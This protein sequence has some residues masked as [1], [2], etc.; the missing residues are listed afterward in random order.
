MATSC[1][2]GRRSG[3]DLALL[4][5][6][7]GPLAVA[8][9][10]PLARELPYA[11]GAALERKKYIRLSHFLVQSYCK[12]VQRKEA[13]RGVPTTHCASPLPD[14]VINR[15]RARDGH[16]L[17]CRWKCMGSRGEVRPEVKDQHNCK[18]RLH[19]CCCLVIMQEHS[20]R[21]GNMLEFPLWRGGNKSN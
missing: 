2:V 15:C 7:C 20:L 9:I 11:A 6:Q 10:Q 21:I 12:W 16:L 8:P 13:S 17:C 5:L 14:T 4:W 19:S 18:Q 1:S 3:S